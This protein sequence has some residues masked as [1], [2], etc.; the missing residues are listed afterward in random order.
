MFLLR[1]EIQ[2]NLP[3]A[4]PPVDGPYLQKY[5]CTKIAVENMLDEMMTMAG[6]MIIMEIYHIYQDLNKL[7]LC[8]RSVPPVSFLPSAPHC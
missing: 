7:C 1:W 8:Q 2:T 6:M 5:F 4:F 3:R